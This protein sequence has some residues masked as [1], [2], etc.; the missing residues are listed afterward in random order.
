MLNEFIFNNRDFAAVG[1][2]TSNRGGEFKFAPAKDQ[3]FM[4]SPPNNFLGNTINLGNGQIAVLGDQDSRVF[5]PQGGSPKSD[6]ETLNL[7]H[8]KKPTIMHKKAKHVPGLRSQHLIQQDLLLK[9]RYGE[10]IGNVVQE[11]K[12]HLSKA[13]RTQSGFS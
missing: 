6:N 7:L 4:K 2:Q 13:S 3:A 8:G 11:R 12:R 1:N 5:S 10:V 9:R